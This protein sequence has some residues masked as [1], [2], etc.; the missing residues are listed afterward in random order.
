M[1]LCVPWGLLVGILSL[2]SAAVTQNGTEGIDL[3]EVHLPVDW[4]DAVANGV[5]F[6]FVKVGEI[7][8][9]DRRAI[10]RFSPN[11][12]PLFVY[13]LSPDLLLTDSRDRQLRVSTTKTYASPLKQ[14]VHSLPGLSMAQCTSHLQRKAAEPIKQTSS[15]NM[16]GTGPRMDRRS[17]E[18][19]RWK[20][21][22]PASFVT[23]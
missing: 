16:E 21:T 13:D 14:P 23:G 3:F 12:T 19:W 22:L 6:V 1:Q 15:S 8:Q 17:P 18:C 2:A 11:Y 10:P 5:K 20:A 9:K 7:D 4:K